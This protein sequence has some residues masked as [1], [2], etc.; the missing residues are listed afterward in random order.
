MLPLRNASK[1]YF[2]TIIICP[3][4]PEPFL[5]TPDTV[6][7]FEKISACVQAGSHHSPTNRPNHTISF[8][9]AATNPMNETSW[10]QPLSLSLS[11]RY[12]RHIVS[13][14][15]KRQSFE[16]IKLLFCLHGQPD[17]RHK[18]YSTSIVVPVRSCAYTA[19]ACLSPK[20]GLL[21]CRN[22]QG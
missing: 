6:C 20:N 19:G 1:F 22:V 2:L 13:V 17:D 10:I 5:D 18:C 21:S 7:P 15:L 11:L 12:K 8:Q 3:P 14:I 4:A 16:W 9:H